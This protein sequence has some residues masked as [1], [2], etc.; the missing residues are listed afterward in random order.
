MATIVAIIAVVAVVALAVIH[1]V[2]AVTIAI[3]VAAV[4]TTALGQHMRGF[5][6]LPSW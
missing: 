4:D 6:W 3:P 1:P 2:T 5:L